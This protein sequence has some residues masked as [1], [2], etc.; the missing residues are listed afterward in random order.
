MPEN[1]CRFPTLVQTSGSD[2]FY[3]IYSLDQRFPLSILSPHSKTFSGICWGKC[4]HLVKYKTQGLNSS[5]PTS[6]RCHFE[7]VTK[8]LW[9]Y[10]SMCC[11]LLACELGATGTRACKCWSALQQRN[12]LHN[13]RGY[14]SPGSHHQWWCA[15]S[16]LNC[17][18]APY[19]WGSL[20]AL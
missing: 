17:S 20:P 12:R 10:S 18:F 1:T 19:H 4:T 11:M 3:Q 6:I 16:V 7:K 2:S 15:H 13:C 9:C 8:L 5:S 14:N